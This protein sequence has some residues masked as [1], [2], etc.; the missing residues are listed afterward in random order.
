MD[1]LKKSKRTN[2]G[3]GVYFISAVFMMLSGLDVIKA[4]LGILGIREGDTLIATVIV[5]I[6]DVAL[7]LYALYLFSKDRNKIAFGVLII[8]NITYIMPLMVGYNAKDIALYIVFVIPLSIIAYIVSIDY[9]GEKKYINMY[10]SI[11]TA[12]CVLAI[13][14]IIVLFV[15]DFDYIINDLGIRIVA[16]YGVIAW[17]F[18][19]AIFIMIPHYI[20]LE[21]HKNQQKV[22]IVLIK[23]MILAAAIYYTGL[24]T[25]IISTFFTVFV[26]AIIFLIV[27]RGE[28]KKVKQVL[29][30]V[31]AVTISFV[32]IY[33]LCVTNIPKNSRLNVI[34][35]TGSLAYET[36]LHDPDE[37][38]VEPQSDSHAQVY[39][40]Q[41]Q[42]YASA[43][44]VLLSYIV[45]SDQTRIETE[46]M[47]TE[48]ANEGNEKYII[49][50]GVENP[51]KFVFSMTKDRVNLWKT[52]IWEFEKSPI[53]GNG[54]RYY[55]LKYVDT[56]PHNIIL[57]LLADVGLAGTSA[58]VIFIFFGI[59]ISLKRGIRN[60]NIDNIK[61]V[62]SCLSMIPTYLLFT[63]V[64]SNPSILFA[65]T[66]F[67]YNIYY[68]YKEKKK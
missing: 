28:R 55:Q 15:G 2:I 56:F 19:P 49:L 48:D 35:S 54:I 68:H 52:A 27:Y 46:K 7:G 18:M 64:Y 62:I 13:T 1:D 59:V 34:Y 41:K 3:S 6:L 33:I 5:V 31:L 23:I 53:F 60:G 37:V 32:L 10:I 8:L 39:D 16:S 20:S 57:E 25:G 42:S 26:S 50:K 66:F 21:S 4:I 63:T 29:L 51:E 24:R 58:F 17:L 44:T 47:L 12:V 43:E 40:I 67:S 14:Y 61:V 22:V 45:S 36:N 38:F 30:R 65:I 11:S 9:D